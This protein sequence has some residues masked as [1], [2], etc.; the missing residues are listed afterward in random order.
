MT[1]RFALLTC[2]AL[3]L[4]GPAA[5]QSWPA[6]PVRVIV[7]FAPGGATD[8]AARVMAQRLTE[9]W[10][11]P[12]VVEN[13][14]G[15]GGNVASE[16]VARS[17]PDGYTLLV[18]TTNTHTINPH[19]YANMSVD[20]Q[21]DFAPITIIAET[22]MALVLHPSVGARTVKDFVALAKAKAGGYS[23][24]TAG[25][26]SAG[27]LSAEMFN[28]LAGVK[29][30]H[31]PYK[32]AGPAMSDLLGGQI[33]VMFAPLAPVA[34]HI[35]AGKLDILAVTTAKRSQM[36]PEVPTIREAGIA[37]FEVSSWFGVFAPAGTDP[38]VVERIR[39]DIVRELGDPG[40]RQKLQEQ[41][42]DPVGNT[43]AEFARQMA[44]ESRTFAKILAEAGVKPE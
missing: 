12:V 29:M 44:A 9:V 40:L 16:L 33:P 5:A 10:K 27:H 31:V 3:L 26:G 32:G 8:I 41:A 20:P 15:A 21:K 39:A 36:F 25:T 1:L 42:L 35:R 28:A 14:P 18:G 6:K 37:G 19:M 11:Q 38:A 34:P 2:V 30:V 7:G 4:A 17:A 13:R 22:P 23:V 43:P 24:G